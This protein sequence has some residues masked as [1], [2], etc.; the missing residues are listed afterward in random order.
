ME[1]SWIIYCMFTLT[2]RT[3]CLLIRTLLHLRTIILRT[4][5]VGRHRV[6]I[7][8]VIANTK[9]WFSHVECLNHFINSLAATQLE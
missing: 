6:V 1:L 9:R 2:G 7:S 5:L 8:V 3:C 4:V